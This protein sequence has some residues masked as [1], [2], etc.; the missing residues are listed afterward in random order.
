MH[1]NWGFISGRAC[2][3][4]DPRGGGGGISGVCTL[5]GGS[6]PGGYSLGGVLRGV[7]LQGGGLSPAFERN[8]VSIIG[9]I[10]QQHGDGDNGNTADSVQG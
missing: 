10:Q 7:N 1:I 4:V 5:P 9:S 6:S 2:S 8:A 3:V